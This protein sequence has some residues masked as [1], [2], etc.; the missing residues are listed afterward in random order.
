[1]ESV[2]F[3]SSKNSRANLMF[4]GWNNLAIKGLTER[5]KFRKFRWPSD[6]GNELNSLDDLAAKRIAR[7]AIGSGIFRLSRTGAYSG[8]PFSNS[9]SSP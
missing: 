6:P 3:S 4:F 7:S 2:N 8:M 5:A 1:M 9:R